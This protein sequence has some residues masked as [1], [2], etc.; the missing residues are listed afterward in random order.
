MADNKS[1]E[2]RLAAIEQELAEIKGRLPP[3]TEPKNWIQEISGSMKDYPEFDEILRL[4]RE[5]RQADRPEPDEK[6][7]R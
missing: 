1:I 3:K 4:G 7:S 2:A 5:M 6:P